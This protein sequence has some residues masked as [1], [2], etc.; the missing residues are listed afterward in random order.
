G[1]SA[2]RA[3]QGG[4]RLHYGIRQCQR[5]R[6]P[7]GL[8]KLE[9]AAGRPIAGRDHDRSEDDPGLSDGAGLEADRRAFPQRPGLGRGASADGAAERG[10]IQDRKS[11]RLNSSHSQKSYAVFCL[12]KKNADLD[13]ASVTA[14]GLTSLISFVST[15][16]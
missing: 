4:G 16:L 13:E 15:P 8:R 11:T 3:A 10:T 6:H 1:L 9:D 12:K 14:D 2:R 5:T 7:Q